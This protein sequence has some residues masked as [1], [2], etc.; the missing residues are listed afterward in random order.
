MSWYKSSDWRRVLE[1]TSSPGN[2]HSNALRKTWTS[3]NG[4]CIGRSPDTAFFAH[5]TI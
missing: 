4:R 2:P 3:L 5:F 1:S